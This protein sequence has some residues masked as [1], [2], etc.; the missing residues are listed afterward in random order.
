MENVQTKQYTTFWVVAK[1]PLSLLLA[2]LIDYKIKNF[3]YVIQ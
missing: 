2:F 3:E 1:W